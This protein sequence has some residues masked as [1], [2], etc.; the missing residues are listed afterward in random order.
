MTVTPPVKPC[1]SHVWGQWGQS[2]GENYILER[3]VC[4]V[5]FRREWRVQK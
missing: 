1:D 3:R 4:R 5:C 2:D